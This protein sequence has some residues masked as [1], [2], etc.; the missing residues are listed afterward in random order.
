MGRAEGYPYKQPVS[1]VRYYL[2]RATMRLDTF[3]DP[4]AA[5][6]SFGEAL[7]EGRYRSEEAQRY[8]YALALMRNRQY[9]K[10][11]VQTR[12]LLLDSP[13]NPA[14]VIAAARLEYAADRPDRAEQILEM[15]LELLPGN[16]SLTLYYAEVLLDRGN[17]LKAGAM[18]T[19]I[20]RASPNDINVLKLLARAS[21]DSGDKS[22]AH[23]YL[24]E[25]YYLTGQV[26][27]AVRQLEIALRDNNMI[28][29]Q[30]ARA[31]ARLNEYQTELRALKEAGK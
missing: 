15:A 27:A 14:Y 26:E 10:A 4:A 16:Y 11:A 18:L 13:E 3:K 31:A 7:T 9:E 6:K 22:E 20:H 30:R 1:D 28:Y 29:Y 8:G 24:A 17:P 2:A 12:Q 25:Y 19:D 21:G 23:Q 5:V